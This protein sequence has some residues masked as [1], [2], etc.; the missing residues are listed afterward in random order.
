M[1]VLPTNVAKDC[2]CEGGHKRPRPVRNTLVLYVYLSHTSR[3]V[4]LPTAEKLGPEPES[5]PLV[6]SSTPNVVAVF[7]RADVALYSHS[8]LG[9]AL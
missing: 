7:L 5:G 6:R 4:I 3:Q 9:Q 8:N 2:W 1:V